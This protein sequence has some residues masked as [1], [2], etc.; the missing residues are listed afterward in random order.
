MTGCRHKIVVEANERVCV[1]CGLVLGPVFSS[2]PL[3]GGQSFQRAWD[4]ATRREQYGHNLGSEIYPLSGGYA[5][6]SP[7][8]R[9]WWNRTRKW[10]APPCDERR[11]LKVFHEIKGVCS[12]MNL[13]R[14]VQEDLRHTAWKLNGRMKG[15]SWLRALAVLTYFSC[16]RR[17]PKEIGE[18]DQAFQ[19]MYGKEYLRI[20]GRWVNLASGVSNLSKGEQPRVREMASLVGV[21]LDQ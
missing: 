19:A 18:I 1:R 7:R 9:A 10:L 3:P 16:R 21:H 4:L 17:A 5:N 20:R 12:Y 13:P 6:I 8:T 15:Y 2:A 11:L 14:G